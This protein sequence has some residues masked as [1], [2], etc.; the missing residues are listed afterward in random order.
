M[1]VEGSVS[2]EVAMQILST[3]IGLFTS[4][5]HKFLLYY[6]LGLRKTD[7]LT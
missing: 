7:L 3:V 5:F 6:V 1:N 4:L 2:I